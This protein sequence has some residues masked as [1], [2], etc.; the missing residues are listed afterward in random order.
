V[1]ITVNQAKELGD[2]V[3]AA[4]LRRGRDLRA[5]LPPEEW[6]EDAFVLERGGR[7]DFEGHEP[8]RPIIADRH[9]K[10]CVQKCAQVGATTAYV[11]LA[12]WLAGVQRRTGI[13]F[14]PTDSFLQDHVKPRVYP[15]FENSRYLK[16]LVRDKSTS[17]IIFRTGAT[18]YHRGLQAPMGVHSTAADFVVFD[19]IDKADQRQATLALERVEHSRHPLYFYLSTPTVP[20]FG[21]ARIYDELSDQ[22]LWRV[23]CP[24]CN[25]WTALRWDR[26][27]EQVGDY[28][29]ELRDRGWG[30]DGD[31]DIHIYCERC[32]KPV[33]RLAAGRWFAERPGGEYHGY[34]ITRLFSPRHSLARL[35]SLFTTALGDETKLTVFHNSA[36]GEAFAAAGAHLTVADLDALRGDYHV[37][38]LAQSSHGAEVFVGV[39]VGPGTGHH[40]VVLEA[41]SLRLLEARATT[42]AGIVG[43]F[44]RHNV[45]GAVV[46]ARPETTK[47]KEL[48]ERHANVWLA[49]Y[50]SDMGVADI[51][52]D[53]R[54]EI[55][56][57][58]VARRIN[59][60]KINRTAS[61]DRMVAM[62]R[63]H[64]IAFPKN[65][66]ELGDVLT[67]KPYNAFYAQL[68]APVRTYVE[69]KRRAAT[70]AVWREV[71]ADHYFHA[72]NYAVVAAALGRAPA[73]AVSA[74][75]IDRAYM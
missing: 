45:V 35:W 38:A 11:G 54:Q 49:E 27:C 64:E 21:I 1:V 65:A 43:V 67:G 44:S 33:D 53:E 6:L 31:R 62:I 56:A 28:D 63:R 12:I 25:R 29:F 24:R 32:G 41:S 75:V 10:I 58:G 59:Y 71:G 26:V 40:Y 20:G 18:L 70:R 3:T 15:V 5:S 42:W 52:P 2:V 17:N 23:R 8:L 13:Y 61:L 36:L 47:A 22:R 57:D 16:A 48:A 72:L 34:K 73:P 46:D 66:A 4:A 74:Y 19:E 37:V 39:D 9:P 50:P 7:Y 69:D 14:F 30:P 68:M 51:A 55:D 60:V